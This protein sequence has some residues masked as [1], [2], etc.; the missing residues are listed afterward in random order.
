VD[1]TVK[2]KISTAFQMRNNVKLGVILN[3]SDH[4]CQ[5]LKVKELKAG[6]NKF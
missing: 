1:H 3:I 5:M 6:K 2:L 4:E